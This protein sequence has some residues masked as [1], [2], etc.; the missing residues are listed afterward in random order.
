[1]AETLY[2]IA[3]ELREQILSSEKKEET[4]SRFFSDHGYEVSPDN[5]VV[6]DDGTPVVKDDKGRDYDKEGL[7]KLKNGISEQLDLFGSLTLQSS[8]DDGRDP[9]TTR[10]RGKG[11]VRKVRSV[12]R[13]NPILRDGVSAYYS[14]EKG[15]NGKEQPP[16]TVKGAWDSFGFVD[17][18]GQDV[19][20]VHDIAQMFSIFRNPVL[21]YFHIVL[22]KNGRIVRQ[23]AMTSGFSGMVRIIPTGGYEKLKSDIEAI[24]YDSA[25]LVHNHPSGNVTPSADDIVST[26]AFINKIFGKKFIGHTILDHDHF[27]LIAAKRYPIRRVEDINLSSHPYEPHKIP[28]LEGKLGEI[29]SPED[30]ARIIFSLHNKGNVVLDLDNAYKVKNILPFSIDDY[31][32]VAFMQEMQKTFVRDRIIIIS[33]EEDYQRIKDKFASTPDKIHQPVLDCIYVN[34]EKNTYESFVEHGIIKHF[35]WQSFLAAERDQAYSWDENISAHPKQGYLFERTPE[36]RKFGRIFLPEE[37]ERVTFEKEL[38]KNSGDGAVPVRKNLPILEALGFPVGNVSISGKAIEKARQ[39]SSISEALEK[40]PNIISDPAAIIDTGIKTKE[41]S[42]Y[43]CL[44]FAY[45]MMLNG[46]PATVGALLEPITTKLKTEYVVQELFPPEAISRDRNRLFIECARNSQFI[47]AEIENPFFIVPGCRTENNKAVITKVTLP[48]KIP[49]RI[50]VF[51]FCTE[52]QAK[53]QKL[54]RH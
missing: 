40:V 21:E 28:K 25:Y 47:Y 33:A 36:Y 2:D 37:I 19:R 6:L 10:G 50:K 35:M 18:L 12:P 29:K 41:D 7:Q 38:K 54:Y 48:Q 45:N 22:A 23:I 20:N 32:P 42:R 13:A 34:T 15:W 17:F 43:N 30:A 24:D 1:M 52:Q 5:I 14:P 46:R 31:D 51:D 8:E 16:W 39:E 9:E 27:T 53:K 26:I 3:S 11:A 44:L 49:D 4:A